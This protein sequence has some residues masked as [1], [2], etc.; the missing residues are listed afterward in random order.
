MNVP[1]GICL[2]EDKQWIAVSNHDAH[3]VLLYENKSSL[4]ETSDPDGILRGTYY[5]HGL[6]FTPDR[7]FILVADASAPYVNIYKGDDPDWRGVRNPLLSF[8]VLNNAD[9]SR[10]RGI[11]GE[12]GPKGI[13]IDK[14]MNIFVTTCE[15]Q[16]LAFF[17]L[18]A[19]L[20]TA[21]SRSNLQGNRARRATEVIY[22]LDLLEELQKKISFFEKSRSW[23]FTAPLR[24][25]FSLLRGD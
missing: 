19:A 13:D 15:T 14:T 25:L 24:Q 4:N 11:P 6:R 23:R 20:Q 8:R 12:G 10:A 18:T 17:D 9:Y 16:P 5:P 22:E 2:S 3:T 1:D 21:C 7:R